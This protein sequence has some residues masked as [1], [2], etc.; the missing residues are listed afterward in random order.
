MNEEHI[1]IA[2]DDAGLLSSLVFILEDEG[3]R[4]STAVNGKEALDAVVQNRDTDNAVDLLITDIEMPELRGTQLIERLNA[5]DLNLPIV[6]VTGYGEKDLLIELIRLG[7]DEFL[8]KPFEPGEV[9][10]KVD[11]VLDKHRK[12]QAEEQEKHEKL[13]YENLELSREIDTY[14]RCFNSLRTEIDSAVVAYNDLLNVQKEGYSV[15]V[16]FRIQAL[17]DLGGDYVDIRN[18]PTGCDIL[19]ADVAGHDLSASYHTVL[20]KAFFDENCRAGKSCEDFFRILNHGIMEKG[21]ND[22][23]VTAIFFRVN[24]ETMIAE[25]VSAGHPP[26]VKIGKNFLHGVEVTTEGPVLGLNEDAAYYKKEIQ[27][28]PRDRFFLYTDGV[29]NARVVDGPTGNKKT[30]GQEGFNAILTDTRNM[31]LAAQVEEAWRRVMLFCRY[32]QTDDMVLF[33]FEIPEKA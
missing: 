2:E 30:L 32:K 3:Y 10:E 31:D 13:V 22:R 18:T 21:C 20:I 5:L 17:R 29:I 28:T 16:A 27:L 25:I 1:L 33:G 26:A 11:E 23:M 8:G 7:C 4:I 24:L 12:K 15:P 6:V 9:L 19:V 14:K